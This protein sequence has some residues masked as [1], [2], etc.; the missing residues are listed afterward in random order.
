MFKFEQLVADCLIRNISYCIV[1]DRFYVWNEHH[2]KWQEW[3]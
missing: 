2:S 1:D 3:H